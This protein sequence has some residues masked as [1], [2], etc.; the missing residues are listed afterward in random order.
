MPVYTKLGRKRI[1]RLW[2]NPDC[3]EQDE[4]VQVWTVIENSTNPQKR[5]V[6]DLQ[7]DQGRQEILNIVMADYKARSTPGPRPTTFTRYAARQ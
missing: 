7:A 3:Y 2:A 6:S 5:F 4:L 1:T